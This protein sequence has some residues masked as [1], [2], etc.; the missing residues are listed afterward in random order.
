MNSL[1]PR[2]RDDR[3]NLS[4]VSYSRD[5]YLLRQLLADQTVSVQHNERDGAEERK[6]ETGHEFR[7][8]QILRKKEP[9]V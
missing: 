9:S 2:D 1:R 5:E 3:V 8:I 7:D 6:S 4:Y